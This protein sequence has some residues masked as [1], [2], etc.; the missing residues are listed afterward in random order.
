MY[1]DRAVDIDK[2]ALHQTALHCTAGQHE[3][4]NGVN[5]CSHLEHLCTVYL[6]SPSH[7]CTEHNANTT[8]MVQG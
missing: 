6:D 8:H 4:I 3:G 2:Q 7:T 5:V 1:S